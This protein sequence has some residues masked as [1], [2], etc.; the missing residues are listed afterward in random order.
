MGSKDGKKKGSTRRS[1]KLRRGCHAFP[2]EERV[3]ERSMIFT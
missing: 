1:V 3:A 2:P